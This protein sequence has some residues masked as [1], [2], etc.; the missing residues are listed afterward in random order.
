[1]LAPGR[2]MPQALGLAH[3]RLRRY[4]RR[5]LGP[6]RS[7][8]DAFVGAISYWTEAAFDLLSRRGMLMHS[9]WIVGRATDEAQV[10]VYT[11]HNRSGATDRRSVEELAA[12]AKELHDHMSDY[13]AMWAAA[14]L[15][16]GIASTYDLQGPEDPPAMSESPGAQGG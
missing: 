8:G 9:A 13:P 1:M 2:S 15:V 4:I 6:S 5:D 14:T 11:Q 12:F 10:S 16:A 7:D 3:D